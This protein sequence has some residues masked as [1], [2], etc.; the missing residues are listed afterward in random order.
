MPPP[1]ALTRLSRKHSIDSVALTAILGLLILLCGP[2]SG[3]QSGACPRESG[4]RPHYRR[5][6]KMKLIRFGDPGSEKPGVLLN[7]GTRVDVSGFGS[8]YDQTFFGGDGLAR[9][10]GWLK[11]NEASAPRVNSSVRLGP[12]VANPAKIICFGLNYQSH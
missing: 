3:S 10:A 4:R 7:D 9:L 1:N 11:Q 12:P 5:D 8:D 6:F 2:I